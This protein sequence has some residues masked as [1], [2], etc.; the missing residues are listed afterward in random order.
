MPVVFPLQLGFA[1]LTGRKKAPDSLRSVSFVQFGEAGAT[2]NQA[3]QASWGSGLGCEF[4]GSLP[5]SRRTGAQALVSQT[6]WK[7]PRRD[8]GSEGPKL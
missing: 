6:E 8:Q 1:T 7:Q 5:V 2:D 4:R 3:A